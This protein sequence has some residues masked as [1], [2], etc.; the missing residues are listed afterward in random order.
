MDEVTDVIVRAMTQSQ[1]LRVGPTFLATVPITSLQKPAS[2]H[3]IGILTEG[4]PYIV[5][6]INIFNLKMVR[7]WLDKPQG[8]LVFRPSLKI[9]HFQRRFSSWV[10]T[11][12]DLI[13]EGA[14]GAQALCQH[15]SPHQ[16]LLLWP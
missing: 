4:E 1:F 2:V 7:V 13:S 5:K 10:L 16:I 15:G 12:R 3:I 11:P 6:D 8:E 9:L 14:H